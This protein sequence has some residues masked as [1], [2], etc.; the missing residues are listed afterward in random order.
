MGKYVSAS[1]LILSLVL[2]GLSFTA[3]P[4]QPKPDEFFRP[5]TNAEIAST[6]VYVWDS[7]IHHGGTGVVFGSASTSS[8]VL[9][10]N[11]VCEFIVNGGFIVKDN[12]SYPIGMYKAYGKHDLCALYIPHNFGI[13]TVVSISDPVLYGDAAVGGHPELLPIII[14]RGHYGELMPRFVV[15]GMD[16]QLLQLIT[17][18]VAPGSSGSPVYDSN[19]ELTNL[20]MG[21]YFDYSLAVPHP[22]L[23]DFANNL[24]KGAW[25]RP[26]ENP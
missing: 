15:K 8:I 13:N 24:D 18:H 25:M 2:L 4:S 14:S 16:P 26:G 6:V 17:T 11:H 20:I 10:N 9:T 5:K 19:G 7:A 21:K 22:F 12:K 23:L 3:K 1:L